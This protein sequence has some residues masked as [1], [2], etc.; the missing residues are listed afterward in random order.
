M[1]LPTVDSV[2][3]A[4]NPPPASD[5]S[6]PDLASPEVFGRVRRRGRV[7]GAP[8]EPRDGKT[9]GVVKKL[10][11]LDQLGDG[12]WAILSP[13]AFVANL[14]AEQF[15]GKLLPYQ[16]EGAKLLI[17]KEQFVLADEMGT[18]KTVQACVAISLLIRLGRVERVLIICPKTTLAVWYDHLTAWVPGL[19]WHPASVPVTSAQQGPVGWVVGYPLVSRRKAAEYLGNQW[20]LVILDEVHELRN[21]DTKR[22]KQ[23][24]QIIDQARYRWGL[25]GTP[26]Q[27]KLEELTAIFAL[28]RPQLGLRAENLAPAAARE[29]IRPYIRRVRRAEALPSLPPKT[30]REIWLTLD[31]KQR[32][33]YKQV[34]DETYRRWGGTSRV[35]FTE[36]WEAINRLKQICNFAPDSS[37]SPKQRKTLELVRS[38]V[39]QGEKVVVFTHFRHYGLDR[40]RPH[41]ARFGVVSICGESSDEERRAAVRQFQS[42][43]QCQVFLATIQTG[44][45]GITLTA[46]NHVIHFDHWWNPAVAWQAE[47]RVH[48][49]GQN[50]PVTVYEFWMKDTVEERVRQVLE[51]KGFLHMEVIEA[52]SEKDVKKLLTL[53]DLKFILGLPTTSPKR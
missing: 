44:G 25:S 11:L 52:L 47:D 46:A 1:P 53:E 6:I 28:I 13:R 32:Q 27:N 5:V 14:L 31:A 34:V 17:E 10:D 36:A 3:V 21:Q 51:H 2:A 42:D 8:R 45:H 7:R 16:V 24:S 22:Y 15:P 29:A 39:A 50:K 49:F 19:K 26:L 38:I 23:V 37:T 33:A 43:P 12:L 9:G 4:I 35:Q 18:G 20:D 40:L 30:R 48:R 41:L